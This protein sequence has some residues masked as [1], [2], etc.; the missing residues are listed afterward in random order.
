MIRLTSIRYSSSPAVNGRLLDFCLQKHP[1]SVN[2]LYHARMVLSVGWFLCVLCTKCT[3]HSNHRFSRVIFQ[4]TKRLLPRSGHFLTTYTR[5]TWR[6]KC[7][8]R[9]KTT[10]WRKKILSCSFCLYRFRRYVSCGAP[11]IN[12]CNPEEYYETPCIFLAPARNRIVSPRLYSLGNGI[13]ETRQY[14]GLEVILLNAEVV[15]KWC[16]DIIATAV[17]CPTVLHIYIFLYKT[18]PT[19]IFRWWQRESSCLEVSWCRCVKAVVLRF[20]LLL[21]SFRTKCTVL[22]GRYFQQLV[23]LIRG[24]GLFQ[25]TD[26][27]RKSGVRYK[28]VFSSRVPLIRGGS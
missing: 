10:Y 12:F 28:L 4:H 19:S 22:R 16:A 3:L 9:W 7:E 14:F 27:I 20:V 24:E 26:L 23:H 8:L 17:K 18:Q 6:Q 5:F 21:W 15:S 1:V 2:C 13:I 25:M 11:I